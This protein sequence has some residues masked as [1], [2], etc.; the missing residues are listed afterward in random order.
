MKK[1]RRVTNRLDWLTSGP[2]QINYEWNASAWQ[3]IFDELEQ[4]MRQEQQK[5]ET[6]DML[7]AMDLMEADVDASDYN[8]VQ[9]MLA[10]IGIRC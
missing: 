5:Q 9:E 7:T 2:Y 1:K 8:E 4:S 3:R 6:V 10:N